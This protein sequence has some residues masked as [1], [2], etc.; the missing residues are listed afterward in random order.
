[1]EEEIRGEEEDVTPQPLNTEGRTALAQ[2]HTPGPVTG[3]SAQ[4]CF[5]CA[6]FLTY[7]LYSSIL[8]FSIEIIT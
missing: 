2:T 4:V 8:Q 5:V 3:R 7:E 1:M 6:Y